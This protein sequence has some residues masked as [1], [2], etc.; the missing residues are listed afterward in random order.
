MLRNGTRLRRLGHNLWALATAPSVD[1]ADSPRTESGHG[2]HLTI[3][4]RHD[5][6]PKLLQTGI[7]AFMADLA[8]G[9]TIQNI[10]HDFTIDVV[11][12]DVFLCVFSLLME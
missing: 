7:A 12:H 11:S 9:F 8:Q 5:L 10:I 2:I 1:Q 3:A 6:G 4:C